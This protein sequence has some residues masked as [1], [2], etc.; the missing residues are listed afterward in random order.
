MPAVS[1]AVH[2]I[3]CMP[4]P[5]RVNALDAMVEF[6]PDKAPCPNEPLPAEHD[7]DATPMASVAVTVPA[8]GDVMNHPMLPLGVKVRL[9]EG[10]AVSM[11]Q[12]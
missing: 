2:E 11:V 6:A 7:S 5:E 12:V 10:T 8:A 4:S 1:V 3:I 9:M